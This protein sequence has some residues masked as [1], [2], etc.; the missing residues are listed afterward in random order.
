MKERKISQNALAEFL[1]KNDFEVT[2]ATVSNWTSGKTSLPMEIA[3][4]LC[5]LFEITFFDLFSEASQEH[6]TM[7]T[8]TIEMEYELNPDH[9]FKNLLNQYTSILKDAK[10]YKEHS[11]LAGRRLNEIYSLYKKHMKEDWAVRLWEYLQTEDLFI[12][13]PLF[14]VV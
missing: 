9:T 2:Q 11:E 14:I 13:W 5:D 6:R 12:D 4:L 7:N 3:P 8:A 1:K 10:Q